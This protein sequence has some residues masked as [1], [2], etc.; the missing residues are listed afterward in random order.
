MKRLVLVCALLAL[1]AVSANAGTVT[2]GTNFGFTHYIPSEGDGLNSLG[3]P[4]VSNTLLMQTFSPGLRVGFALDD[5]AQTM[6]D[7]DSSVQI[8]SMNEGTLRTLEGMVAYRYHFSTEPTA[9]Y[10]TAG[11]GLLNVSYD[12]SAGNSF[13]FGGGIGVRNTL[14]NGNGS[15][16]AEIRVD[17]Q[18]KSNDDVPM[19]ELTAVGLRVGFDLNLR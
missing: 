3:W 1:V 15:L 17:R 5:A 6:L 10:V 19:D 18:A 13:V 8:L 7:F 14:A 11:V 12:G 16:R 9:P 4:Q 2:V